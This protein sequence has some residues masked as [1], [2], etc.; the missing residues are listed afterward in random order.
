MSC[1]ARPFL[2]NRVAFPLTFGCDYAALG[3]MQ[4]KSDQ[5]GSATCAVLI[6]T[7]M[8]IGAPQLVPDARR[9]LLRMQGSGHRMSLDDCDCFSCGQ[10]PH[11]SFGTKDPA[12]NISISDQA[13]GAVCAFS[14]FMGLGLWLLMKRIA[15]TFISFLPQAR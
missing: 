3:S 2:P 12:G 10:R 11:R 4:A 8:S 6:A 14:T 7:G 13:V 5:F 9:K 15:K 1:A